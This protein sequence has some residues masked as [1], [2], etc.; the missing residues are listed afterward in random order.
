MYR[1]AYIEG[2]HRQW[3]RFWSSCSNFILP[4]S[5][6]AAFNWREVVC[7]ILCTNIS[8]NTKKSK[9]TFHL[10]NHIAC[11]SLSYI[12]PCVV[13]P[14]VFMMTTKMMVAALVLHTLRRQERGKQNGWT[15]YEGERLPFV[16]NFFMHVCLWG[17]SAAFKE[18]I[19]GKRRNRRRQGEILLME[20]VDS[21]HASYI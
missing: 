15:E 21:R 9:Y 1:F 6:I 3:F 19:S 20:V 17:Y 11:Q 12:M 10:R 5:N 18:F 16:L 13:A 14:V 7:T 4:Q 8:I 2:K